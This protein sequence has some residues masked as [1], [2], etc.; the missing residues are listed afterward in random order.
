MLDKM[1][2]VRSRIRAEAEAPYIG[3][4]SRERSLVSVVLRF[5][6]SSAS[7]KTDFPG[8]LVKGISNGVRYLH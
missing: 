4:F 1:R 7:L 3:K 8:L 5:D 2:V 6:S